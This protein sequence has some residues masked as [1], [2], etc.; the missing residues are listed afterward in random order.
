[1]QQ[2]SR[3]IWIYAI[4]GAIAFGAVSYYVY[5]KDIGFKKDA[6]FGNAVGT[7]QQPTAETPEPKTGPKIQSPT[8]DALPSSTSSAS[9]QQS[10]AKKA[11]SGSGPPSP[12][13]APPAAPVSASTPPQPSSS[14]TVTLTGI[15][16][17]KTSGSG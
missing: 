1:M 3:R 7:Q 5:A 2:E 17:Q 12:A 4:I 11:V 15:V 16:M 13:V 6:A 9:Q 8:T 10:S 14:Q